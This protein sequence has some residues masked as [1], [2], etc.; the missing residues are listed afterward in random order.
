[1]LQTEMKRKYELKIQITPSTMWCEI[2]FMRLVFSWSVCEQGDDLK[3]SN[4]VFF[5]KK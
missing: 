3:K 2:I 5:I 4:K 1:M